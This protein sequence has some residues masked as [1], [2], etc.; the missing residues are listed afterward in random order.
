M[1]KLKILNLFVVLSLCSFILESKELFFECPYDKNYLEDGW[2]DLSEEKTT[3]GKI[4]THKYMID[5]D[6]GKG[7]F[8]KNKVGWKESQARYGRGDVLPTQINS[9]ADEVFISYCA[10]KDYCSSEEK[11]VD[12]INRESLL[13]RHGP[14]RKIGICKIIEKNNK[15]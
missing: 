5:L 14:K 10:W 7:T 3:D 4:Y 8:T 9:T 13:L 12:V 2:G 6:T 11:S 15:F 1:N